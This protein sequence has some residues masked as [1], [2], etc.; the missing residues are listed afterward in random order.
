MSMQK[1]LA[2]VALSAVAVVSMSGCGS[3]VGDPAAGDPAAVQSGSRADVDYVFETLGENYDRVGGD[4]LGP[5]QIAQAVPTP[6]SVTAGRMEPRGADML[7]TGTVAEVSEGEA[8]RHDPENEDEYEVVDFDDPEADER[9][10]LVTLDVETA[11]G[12]SGTMSLPTET[13]RVGL[14]GAEDAERFL[15]GLQG[16]ER[17]VVF[18]GDNDGTLYA[19]Q[20]GAAM[21]EVSPDGVL[22][23]PAMGADAKAFMGAVDTIRELEG[24]IAT[25]P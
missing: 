13:F 12:P 11:V 22:S 9:S 1:S 23:F 19:M 16:M 21:G 10:A 15:T 8:R 3:A 17:V 18:L 25:S 7:L 6:G 14:A 5:T 24:L 4:V 2:A 20:G